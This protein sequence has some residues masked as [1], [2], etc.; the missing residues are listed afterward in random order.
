MISF[1]VIDAGEYYDLPD[2]QPGFTL[3]YLLSD[4]GTFQSDYP[5]SGRNA[6]HLA[7]DSVM[8]AYVNGV[9]LPNSRF[10]IQAGKS[11]TENANTFI[12][13]SLLDVFRRVV[14]RGIAS[15][16]NSQRYDAATP[17]GILNTLFTQAQAAGRMTGLTWAFT[18]TLDS[19]GVAWTKNLSIEYAAGTSYL[20]IIRQMVDSGAIDIRMDGYAVQVYNGGS[21]G[22]DYATEG[23]SDVV[24]SDALD[25]ADTPTQ[26]T[27]EERARYSLLLGSDGTFNEYTS[28]A[29]PNGPFG[30][31]DM[32]LS[33]GSLTVAGTLA[34][35]NQAAQLRAGSTIQQ[36]TRTLTLRDSRKLPLR[37]YQCGDW[38]YERIDGT[39]YRRRVRAIVLTGG[40]S[41]KVVSGS[42]TLNDLILERNI[43]LSRRV[44]GI[45]GGSTGGATGGITN[46]PDTTTPNPVTGLVVT[47]A[48]YLDDQGLTR[49]Y[50]LLDWNAP[51]NN[52]DGSVCTDIERYEV[53]YRL[54]SSATWTSSASVADTDA[55]VDGLTP[56]QTYVFRVRVRDTAPAPHVSA[57]NTSSGVVVVGDTT[58]PPK[59]STPVVS[60]YL[61]SLMIRWDGKTSAGA[62]M[63]ADCDRIEVH[64]STVNG[65][66]PD[67]TTMM[68]T[69]NG[70][71]PGAVV[72]TDGVAGTTYYFKFIATDRSG[73]SSVASTQASGVPTL[74]TGS[75]IGPGSVF[76]NNLVDEAFNAA[77]SIFKDGC[78]D[79]SRWV[80]SG[81][82]GSISVV[83]G[84]T[85]APYGS[86]AFQTDGYS[87]MVHTARIAF[88]PTETYRITV[89][90][91]TMAGTAKFYAGIKTYGN[92]GVT[93][94][95]ANS[96][97]VY[98]AASNQ[99]LPGTWTTYTGF[100][101]GT[102]V[103]NAFSGV[104][105]A[106]TPNSPATLIDTCRYISP[107]ILMSYQGTA[108]V[109]SSQVCLV[110]VEAVPT[111]YVVAMNI[112][113]LT[114]T[115]AKIY[116]MAV[117]KLLAGRISAS[118]YI[119]A[120]DPAAVHT[121]MDATGLHVYG[122][123]DQ[124]NLQITA[125]FGVAGSD[126]RWQ[127]RNASGT[128][129]ASVTETGVLNGQSGNFATDIAVNGSP[130]GSDKVPNPAVAADLSIL[131]R[132][133]WGVLAWGQRTTTGTATN[134]TALPFLELQADI[135]P[136][137]RYRIRVSPHYLTN[138]TA[139]GR[140]VG[141]LRYT[142]GGAAVGVASTALCSGRVIIPTAGQSVTFELERYLMTATATELRVLYCYYSETGN[143]APVASGSFP[144]EMVIEDVGPDTGDLGIDRSGSTTT[145]KTYTKTY[146]A[147]WSGSYT[148]AGA[149]NSYYGNKCDQGDGGGSAGNGKAMIGFP[150]T[151]I[152]SDLTGATLTKLEVWLYFSSWYGSSGTAVIG[153]H[154]QATEPATFSGTTNQVQSAGWPEPGGRWVTLPSGL[155]AGFK[156]GTY[157]GIVLG[158]GPT[159]STLYH[160]V[161]EGADASVT[162]QRPFLRATYTK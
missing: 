111:G 12:G 43:R 88:D 120:G 79:T 14:V 121:R 114:V 55:T 107:L 141:F 128:I 39:A 133:P 148:G 6:S 60:A 44:D 20:A 86:T 27:A 61:E 47:T 99:T 17:G 147:T 146:A 35:V 100:I 125:E 116:S 25:Y 2:M 30:I 68:A 158:P 73:N 41:E 144:V 118:Q 106:N 104:L 134:T 51:T 138:D 18:S 81:S 143:G 77:S 78:S 76:L 110:K 9:E 50:A 162:A 46:R 161:A 153:V 63:P 56:G 83:S 10:W 122:L 71:S 37:D 145:K 66:T 127:V 16:V 108:G 24:L 95:G 75:D 142:T 135:V 13:K 102:S 159:T 74:V 80:R 132:I 117:E 149:A 97:N 137:R 72:F 15:P 112:A 101:R 45:T 36:F 62:D 31:E 42:L 115:D 105:G 109:D 33:N 139:N 29:T 67:S 58:A 28:P 93:P 103:A 136:G 90:A 57:W 94:V 140:V 154:G 157:K 48:E 87:Q 130:L 19:A 3:G 119:A 98:L 32:S 59:P 152:V 7:N 49:A 151:T 5:K 21:L 70:K 53:Q 26:W 40:D 84:L 155:W 85:D 69:V 34:D 89:V 4:V 52:T 22:S 113:D 38:I 124:G 123:D 150:S 96:G 11:A 65:F 126:D 160:G 23:A 1:K 131:E 82:G 8:V 64:R 91:R 92:D 54:S 129:V 156:S